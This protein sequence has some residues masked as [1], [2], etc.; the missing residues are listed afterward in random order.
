MCRDMLK[1]NLG[2]IA[3]ADVPV[4]PAEVFVVVCIIVAK[5]LTHFW[6]IVLK[7]VKPT[8]GIVVVFDCEHFNTTT[9]DCTIQLQR[10]ILCHSPISMFSELIEHKIVANNQHLSET[11]D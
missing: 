1:F 2:I 8:A 3:E 9:W 11:P 6:V 4:M 7:S 5:Y 10:L